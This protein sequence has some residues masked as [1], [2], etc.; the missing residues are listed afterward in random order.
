MIACVSCTARC[1]RSRVIWYPT[2]CSYTYLLHS[3]TGV[4][5]LLI[6]MWPWAFFSAVQTLSAH[7]VAFSFTAPVVSGLLQPLLSN[8][9]QIVCW[10]LALLCACVCAKAKMLCRQHMGGRIDRWDCTEDVTHANTRQDGWAWQKNSD[11]LSATCSSACNPCFIFLW[12]L[13]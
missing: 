6:G 12:C 8:S 3:K 7:N 5:I 4:S 10:K 13:Q 9:Y 1:L 11:L 2:Q